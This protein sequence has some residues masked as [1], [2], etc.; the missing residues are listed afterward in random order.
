MILSER[1]V[2]L[3]SITY[4]SDS[5]VVLGYITNEARRFYAYVSNRVERIRKYSSP[6]QWRYVSTHHN[7]ADVATRLVTACNLGRL[8]W[9][10]GPQ[11]LKEP[12]GSCNEDE[13]SDLFQLQPN[14]PK[15]HSRLKT[16]VTALRKKTLL[17]A[18]WFAR[19][20]SWINLIKGILRLIIFARRY[21]LAKATRESGSSE[22]QSPFN[23]GTNF[24]AVE[25]NNQAELLILKS[26]QYETFKE[27]I[28]CV[29]HGK[30]LPKS[31]PLLKLSPSLDTNHILRIGG[32][33]DRV[34]ITNE[35]RHPVIVP[36]S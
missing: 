1:V 22:R 24:T 25:V 27:E 36:G 29:T 3:D 16:S 5:R 9:L 26:A 33:L 4:Y 30:P 31:S 11:F 28:V 35:E 23:E 15:V 2:E 18:G 32:R 7:S 14:D 6:N 17:G 12:K 13:E 10:S 21:R 8:A 20:S 34:N 19:F